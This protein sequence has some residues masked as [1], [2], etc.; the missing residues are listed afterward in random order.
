MARSIAY[1]L[2]YAVRQSQAYGESKHDERGKGKVDSRAPYKTYSFDSMK[3]RSDIAKDLGKWVKETYPEIRLAKEITPAMTREFLTQKAEKGCRQATLTAYTS[4]VRAIFR[5][6]E[7]TFKSPH[8]GDYKSLIPCPEARPD[9]EPLR[10]CR[11]MSKEDFKTVLKTT[12]AGSNINKAMRV[13]EATGA[14]SDGAVGLKGSDIHVI[15]GAVRVGLTEKGGRYREVTVTVPEHVD[16][17][18]NL[19]VV[20]NRYVLE[21]RGQ[22]IKEESLQKSLARHIEQAGLKDKYPYQKCHSIRKMWAQET[23]N[24]YRETHGKLETIEHINEQ[25]GHSAGRD[26]ALLGCYVGDIH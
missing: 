23:Y 14:R 11:G 10:T 8:Y 26:V 19:S 16:F 4:H 18:K 13:I 17:L 3:A 6:M 22:P 2:Q 1:Q 20:G 21:H 12:A 15:D 24:A 25:L 5:Y 7:H 9:L